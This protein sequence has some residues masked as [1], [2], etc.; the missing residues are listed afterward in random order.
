MV[1]LLSSF[2]LSVGQWGLAVLCAMMFGFSRTGFNG[3]SILAIPLM[4]AIFGGK[5]SSA[6]ILP[7]LIAGD[8]IAVKQYNTS[9]NWS[10]IIKLLPWSFGGLAVGVLVGKL[11]N[12]RQFTMIIGL[13][14][15]LCLG[16][17]IWMER[18]GNTAAIPNRWWLGAITGLAGG[19]PP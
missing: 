13:S 6:I 5:A 14:V 10:Y 3:V 11:V 15:L 1:Q 4:A 17:M 12:D 18:R 7:L 2:H 9:T 19:S 16:L 8:L